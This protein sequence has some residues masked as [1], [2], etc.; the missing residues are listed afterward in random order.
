MV[1]M[2]VAL[3]HY[4]AADISMMIFHFRRFQRY[5]DA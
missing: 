2:L 1:M 5:A 3:R 4:A